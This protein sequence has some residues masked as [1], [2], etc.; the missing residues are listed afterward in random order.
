[1][2][3]LLG[4][5]CQMQQVHTHTDP[6]QVIRQVC[7]TGPWTALINNPLHHRVDRGITEGQWEWTFRHS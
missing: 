7:S 2:C 4:Q 5:S 1:M 3:K 6:P